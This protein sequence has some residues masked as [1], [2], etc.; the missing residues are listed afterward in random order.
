MV[1]YEIIEHPA[2]IGVKAY[3]QSREELFVHMAQGMMSLIVPPNE[4][5]ERDSMEVT[6]EAQGWD[7][8]L[9]SWLKELLYRFDT[10]R[11]L[12]R[13]FEV[14]LLESNLIEVTAR[15]EFLDPSRHH[16]DKEIK[17]VTYC[18]LALK[19]RPDGIWVA[20]VIFDI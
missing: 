2:E 16:V 13:S 10:E 15:G 8:L 1:P 5:Q 4:V 9:V 19:Q 12:A 3:G 11:F 6:A 17:A 14:N 18:D 7:Q 20:R